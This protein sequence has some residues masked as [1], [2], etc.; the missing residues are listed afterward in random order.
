MFD[1]FFNTL[2]IWAI[3]V[4]VFARPLHAVDYKVHM[5]YV[6]PS[7]RTPQAN[8]VDNLK[9]YITTVQDWYADQ[10]DR[11]G[12]GR[13]SFVYER[14]GISGIPVVRTVNTS[15]TDVEMRTDLWSTTGTAASNA[16]LSI[17][18][19]GQVWM[20]FPESHVQQ[21]DGS[22]IGGVAFGASYGSGSDAG[23]A[24]CGSDFLP[25]LDPSW[26]TNNRNYA[27]LTIQPIGPRPL[28][29]DKSFPWYEGKTLSSI[30]SSAL[31]AMTHE[32][33]HAFG[34]GHD[35]RND[36]NFVGNLMGNGLR[37][38]RGSIYRDLYP[39]DSTQLSYAAAL[40]L[41]VSRYF[42][43]NKTFTEDTKPS[44]S[45]KTSGSVTPVNGQLQ[46][47]FSTSDSSGLVAAFLRK[48]GDLVSEIKL[49]S[50]SLADAVLSTP[51]Y[52]P[53]QNDQYTIDV[54]DTQGNKQS[55][56]VN[57]NVS[58]GYNRAPQ[59]FIS[60]NADVA[61]LGKSILLDA[62]ASTDPD[63]SAQSLLYDWDLNG[64]GLFESGPMSSSRLL[65]SF[66]SLGNLLISVK[67][68]DPHGAV[69][70]SEP[71]SLQIVP[72]P[73]TWCLL[74]LAATISMLFTHRK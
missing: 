40:T 31:G 16:G 65:T 55:T 70:I 33:G 43:S 2:M 74:L 5:G 59:P 39:N 56:N 68:T 25:R 30:A 14:S 23:M 60:L 10:M 67:I 21:A 7:N 46:V 34:L 57:I 47:H 13:K 44:L 54:Y 52:T 71:L 51:Y 41:N 35:F 4:V 63:D 61:D 11:Y 53:G 22:I 8:A 1:R 66:N 64:D 27:G 12:F 24:V 26:L 73:S 32:L 42:N 17:W 58:T 6:I 28:V 48:N 18:A 62:S 38:W 19:P 69:S 20:L 72:E 45:I 36:T 29:Q 3:L 50:N 49:S 37:G 9:T 15:K